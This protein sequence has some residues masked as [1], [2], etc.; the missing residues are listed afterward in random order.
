MHAVEKQAL[1][2]GYMIALVSAAVLSTTAIFIRHLT[3]HYGMP[4]LVL[5]MW[6]D[7]FTASALLAVLAVLR[8]ALLRIPRR[9]V[10]YLVGYGFVLAIFN[11][12]WTLS[13]A[14]NGAAI[15]T[16]L[17]YCSAGFT[18]LLGW[19]LLNERLDRVKLLTVAL[20]LGGCVLVAEAL[21]PA[22]WRANPL[23]IL[24][25]VLSGLFYAFYSLMGR[26]AAQRGLN[27]WTTVL[28]TFGF[29]GVFLL[30]F[31]LLPGG[32]LPGAAAQAADLF[33]LGSSATGWGLLILLAAGPTLAG[34]GL[35][36]VSLG[37][38]PS[39]V[40]NLVVTLEPVFTAAM[41]YFLFGEILNQTQVGGAVLILGGVVFL[42]LHE[43]RLAAETAPA[44]Q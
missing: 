36:N 41:A 44:S 38:L 22:A 11:S 7:F 18:A 6:R 10:L 14:L 33:W 15:A 16:V 3:E 30:G 34:F 31:N 8:P 26:S 5:A 1:S 13:V 24:T 4:A 37:Y 27:P 40:A 17:A 25:G 2:R 9:A 43:G 20:S 42:R 12:F 32:L 23:G 35:Y 29:A 39:S 19:W 21:D 28:Y